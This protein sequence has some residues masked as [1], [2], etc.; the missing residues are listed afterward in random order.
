M[1]V[2]YSNHTI[3]IAHFGRYLALLLSQD[4]MYFGHKI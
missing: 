3:I 2:V 1:I 4:E